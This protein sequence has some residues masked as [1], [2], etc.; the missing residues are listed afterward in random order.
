MT[1]TCLNP[2]CPHRERIEHAKTVYRAQHAE[3]VRLQTLLG[4]HKAIGMRRFREGDAWELRVGSDTLYQLTILRRAVA[5]RDDTIAEQARLIAALKQVLTPSEILR[6][7]LEVASMTPSPLTAPVSLFC[8]ST[9]TTPVER[10]PL[11]TVLQHIQDGRY[12]PYVEQLRRI[13]ATQ[14]EDA[15]A[16]AKRRSIA[17]TPAGT[18]TA[19]NNASLDT[20]SGCL[21]LDLDDLT[22]LDHARATIGADPHLVYM[23]VSPSGQGLKL[24]MH[25]QCYGDADA[26]RHVW[27]AVEHYLVET[28]P[29]LAVSNDTLCKDVSR[30]CY[31]SWDP[32]LLTNPASRAFVAPPRAPCAPTPPQQSRP[33]TLPTERR[34]RY[35]DQA[36]ATA[37]KLLDA[38]VAR[39]PTSKGTR[40]RQRLKASRLL[41][42]YIAG[43]VLT[44]AEAK[45]GIAAAVERNTGHLNRAWRVIEH[46]FRYGEAAPITLDQLE[47]EYELWVNTHT[48][49]SPAPQQSSA[50]HLS[51]DET[52]QSLTAST[53]Y[54][55][56]CGAR[57]ARYRAQLRN[58]PYFGT[59]ERRGTGIPRAHVIYKETSHHE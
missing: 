28:Y 6:A 45:A 16:T 39:T 42:G 4:R 35:A 29:D 25:V 5:Q 38:S 54:Q 56:R 50:S 27:F 41:G 31:M 52:T 24:G 21:N 14:G 40:D 23:F 9:T 12:R 3:I 33:W 19:R 15:Y 18:F 10:L 22:D 59:P 53:P 26:Y 48:K 1:P 55:R 51:H 30:L 37:I 34:Q 13:L 20:P 2:A 43:G 47:A 17:F 49:T 11:A 58:D 8:G 32:D 46:G 44:E 36:I 57:I 7:S